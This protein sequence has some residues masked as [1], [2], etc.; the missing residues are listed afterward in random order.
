MKKKQQWIW[1]H[2]DYPKFHYN[3]QELL[4][5]M[6]QIAQNV[7]QVKALITLLDKEAQNR[8]KIDLFTSDIVSTSVIEGEHLSRESVRSSIR[9]KIDRKFDKEYDKSTYHT[10]ALADI[11]M[12]TLLN[13]TPLELEHMHKWHMLC[14]PTLQ[15]TLLIY[16]LECF[17]TIITCKLF[18]VLLGRKKFIM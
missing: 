10:D 17:E 3:I 11:L 15:V 18:L 8:I 4:P 16:D 7:G 14:P 13:V 5:K 2:S 6:M 1:Q 12:D 9:K